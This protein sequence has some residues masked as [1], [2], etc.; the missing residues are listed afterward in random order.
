MS[1]VKVIAIHLPQFHTIP[2]N[3]VWWGEGFTEWTNVRKAQPLYRN[4]YQ[5]RVPLNGNYYDLLDPAVRA[6]QADIARAHGIYGFCYYH[7]WFA[8]KKLLE[9]PIEQLLERQEPDFPFCLSWANE[10]WTRA[11]D[12]GENHILMPQSYGSVEDWRAHIQYLIKAFKDR[13]YIMVDGKPLILIYRTESIRPMAAMLDLWREEVL[14]AGFK[15]LHVVSM[16][17][18]FELDT[19]VHLFDAYA[20][21]EPMWSVRNMPGKMAKR[22]KRRKKNAAWLRKKLGFVAHGDFSFDYGDIWK[23]IAK[24]PLPPQNYPGAF[25]DWDNSPRRA[26]DKALIMR[27]FSEEAFRTGFKAQIDKA[28]RTEAPFLFFNAWNEWAEGTYLEPDEKRGYF[29][30]ETIRDALQSP[31]A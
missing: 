10:P 7:Y 24:R 25:A 1:D 30:L 27:N 28:R 6:W 12:G 31:T 26:I 5:P 17:G 11:W 20:E 29:F 22:E 19:R 18:G 4:H 14:K 13:R 16:A 21:F 15:G 3:D 8:G 9:R 2:E 23:T